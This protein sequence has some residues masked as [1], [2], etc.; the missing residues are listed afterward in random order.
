MPFTKA[1]M[2]SFHLVLKI[3]TVE[4]K[5]SFL[6]AMSGSPDLDDQQELG[7][8]IGLS[9][10][11]IIEFLTGLLTDASIKNFV[12]FKLHSI[13]DL[14]GTFPSED[15]TTQSAELRLKMINLYSTKLV[16][17]R[18]SVTKSGQ[19]RLPISSEHSDRSSPVPSLSWSDGW[20]ED[21]EGGP[22]FELAKVSEVTGLK[23]IKKSSDPDLD[24]GMEAPVSLKSTGK[25]D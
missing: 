3:A 18:Q 6:E 11:F 7:M 1:L 24:V 13:I 12:V 9:G 8:I 22:V 20:H 14:M 4:E 2:K 17:N 21:G 25:I 15:T 10:P 19:P 16:R 5:L 23:D